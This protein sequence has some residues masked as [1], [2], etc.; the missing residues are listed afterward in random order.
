L[1]RTDTAPGRL[2]P[3]Q[4]SIQ[5]I[6]RQRCQQKYNLLRIIEMFSGYQPGEVRR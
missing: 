1:N 4:A 5:D 6:H 2:G 3:H